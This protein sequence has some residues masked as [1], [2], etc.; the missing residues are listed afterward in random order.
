MSRQVSKSGKLHFQ[1]FFLGFTLSGTVYCKKL[2]K[3]LEWVRKQR[4]SKICNETFYS[5]STE[6]HC[7]IW[8]EILFCFDRKNEKGRRF[9]SFFPSRASLHFYFPPKPSKFNQSKMTNT[10]MVFLRGELTN[11]LKYMHSLLSKSI[12]LPAKKYHNKVH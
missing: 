3:C 4:E 2:S 9:F 12:I 10:N 1:A 7:C 5:K 11:T 6:I 8:D